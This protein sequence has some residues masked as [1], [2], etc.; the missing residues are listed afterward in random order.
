LV[1]RGPERIALLGANG[2]GKTTLVN[3]I[4]GKLGA[5]RGEV[6][7]HVPV[8]LL[9]QRLDV[10]DDADSVAA[11]A[12]RLAPAATPGEV[13]TSL[14]RFGLRG[15]EADRPVGSL[16]GGERLRA[17]LAAIM[18]AGEPPQLLILDEPTNSLDL[19]A[20]EHLVSALSGFR[21]ALIAV[22]HD[23]MF[24]R[25]IGV[26]RWLELTP[27]GLADLPEE[28]PETTPPSAPKPR[29]SLT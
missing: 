11:A 27:T 29:Q 6:R 1:V 28:P 22:S 13:R 15:R 10:L 4:V 21:G 19:A 25:E 26:T 5:V 12:G 24:L 18:L 8:R 3:V 20:V 2:T 7:L 17:T 9:P 23:W 14:A 16:S